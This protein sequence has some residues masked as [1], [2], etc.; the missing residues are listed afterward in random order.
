MIRV[1]VGNEDVPQGRERDIG[2]HELP[3]HAV[4]AV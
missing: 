3:R 1:V 2:A 4:A